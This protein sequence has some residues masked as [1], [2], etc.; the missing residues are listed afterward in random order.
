MKMFKM[1]L[2][3]AAML[4]TST[5]FSFEGNLGPPAE[6]LATYGDVIQQNELRMEQ[7]WIPV[8]VQLF[9]V[10]TDDVYSGSFVMIKYISHGTELAESS[11][12]LKN[13]TQEAYNSF[14]EYWNGLQKQEAESKTFKSKLGI[15]VDPLDK[16]KM[17]GVS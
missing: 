5:A 13:H 10:Q 4:A 15:F 6:D 16:Q 11:C 2:L 1:V 3:L 14:M 17:I 7:G 12:I 9:E 8:D